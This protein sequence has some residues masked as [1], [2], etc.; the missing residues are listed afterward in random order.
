MMAKDMIRA[1]GEIDERFVDQA[2]ETK[3][4]TAQKNKDA[5]KITAAA[6]ILILVAGISLS[7]AY[8]AAQIPL[9]EASH[10]VNVR[11]T[12]FAPTVLAE[13]CLVGMTEEELFST[14]NTA[15]FRGEILSLT[16][17]VLNFNGRNEYRA[18]AAV[19]VEKNLRGPFAA[20]ETVEILL[21]CSVGGGIQQTAADTVYAMREGIEGIFMPALYDEHSLFHYNNATL[22]LADLA[23]C[24]FPD[25]V[26]YAFLMGE[27]G[28][29]FD[30]SAYPSLANA[31]SLEDVEGF[32]G[33]MI[34][35]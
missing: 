4:F 20:G 17:V 11:K 6:A 32:V 19:R 31:N 27:E 18:I 15:I 26:R 7:I 24:G 28:L 5:K 8:Q 2:I 33:K 12:F 21:P 34:A 16:N 3:P 22:S 29:I 13:S 35:P 14:Y 1:L 25:G 30:R 10:G 23:P 9:S